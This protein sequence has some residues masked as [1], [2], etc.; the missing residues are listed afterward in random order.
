MQA[1]KV[2]SIAYNCLICALCFSLGRLTLQTSR[3]VVPWYRAIADPITL[4]DV[5]APSVRKMMP[6]APKPTTKADAAIFERI[7]EDKLKRHAQAIGDQEDVIK[8]MDF[9][10]VHEKNAYDM[11]EPVINCEDEV[12]FGP[13]AYSVGDGPKFICGLRT[14]KS[15]QACLV[16]SV[17]S[18]WN[19]LFELAVV[20]A[21]PECVIHTFDGTMDLT[22]KPLPELPSNIVFHNWNIVAECGTEQ[23]LSHP[24]RCF[25]SI[26]KDLHHEN[27]E[28]TWFKIDCEGCEYDV[29]PKVLSNTH[30]EHMMV[31]VHGTDPRKIQSLFHEFSAHGLFI[32]HKERN[33]DGCD[34]YRCVEFSLMTLPYAKS[35]LEA[36]ITV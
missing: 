7:W 29:L 17:G 32:F 35:V 15:K 24:S 18:N 16:Y 28:I 36:F 23:K 30:I 11:Y 6:S 20:K 3:G 19:F 4:T 8:N 13:R 34:G 5:H 21:A 33:H 2:V 10:R 12:R 31:E 22:S 25:A 27:S 14:L 9:S 1:K 26:L